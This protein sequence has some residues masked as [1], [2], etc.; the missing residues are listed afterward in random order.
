MS[1]TPRASVFGNELVVTH[2]VWEQYTYLFNDSPDR[3][4]MLNAC[5][6]WFFGTTQRVMMR[7]VVLGISRLTDPPTTGKFPN[8]VLSSLLTDP[9]FPEHKGLPQELDAAITH[10][11]L[12]AKPIRNTAINT[13][14]I[15]TMKPQCA[16]PRN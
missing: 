1:S 5:A 11:Q 13:S 2:D 16:Q 10:L 8:L 7:E 4:R 12:L 15:W 3:I 9:V 6:R 14:R